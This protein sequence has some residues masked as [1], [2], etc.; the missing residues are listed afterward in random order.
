MKIFKYELKITDYQSLYLFEGAKILHIAEQDGKL[1][2]WA[3][4][5][6]VAKHSWT[7]KIRI[8]GKGDSFNDIEEFPD[9]LGTAIMR[10][11]SL[12]FHVFANLETKKQ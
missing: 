4:V 10:S 7:V 5:N 11:G 2:L 1:F 12:V 8:V 6:P 9:F 3:L